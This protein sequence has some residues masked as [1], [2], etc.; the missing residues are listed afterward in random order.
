MAFCFN[1]LPTC[2]GWLSIHKPVLLVCS[3]GQPAH[4]SAACALAS[5]LQGELCAAV[6]MALWCQS[7]DRQAGAGAG[8]GEAVPVAVAGNGVADLGPLPWLYGEWDAVQRAQGKVLVVWSPE[9]KR[10]FERTEQKTQTERR[11]QEG[12]RKGEAKWGNTTDDLDREE[13]WRPKPR[14]L[15]YG[16]EKD[17]LL[18]EEDLSEVSSEG[19]SITGPVL[20]ATLARLKGVLREPGRSH[21]VVLISLRGLNHN[22]D[23]PDELQGVPRYS[24]PGDFRGLIQELG[25]IASGPNSW[26]ELG[27]D[28]WPRLRSK[29]LSLWLA[30]R[31]SHQLK[32]S[33]P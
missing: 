14:T 22:R 11:K 1:L 25:G 13:G 16:T 12:T 6:R 30:R 23:I 19:S 8:A 28:C 31:L 9:A 10:V 27:C 5:I 20:R 32:T 3:S 24:L 18:E 2:A 4:V 17:A 7:S 33:L 15:T 21:P 29:V 26:E